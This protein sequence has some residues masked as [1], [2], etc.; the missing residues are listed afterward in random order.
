MAI[1]HSAAVK[2]KLPADYVMNHM[3]AK[4][5]W[6]ESLKID[7]FDDVKDKVGADVWESSEN[8]ADGNWNQLHVL[9]KFDDDVNRRLDEGW[10]RQDRVERLTAA[11]VLGTIVMLVLGAVYSYLSIDLK[12]GGAYRGRLR[13][14]AL[15]AILL[16]ITIVLLNHV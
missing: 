11:G 4:D 6:E 9:V 10:A 14:G 16:V 12:T 7:S 2:L 15:A 13:A 8:A 3:I 5:V 1:G